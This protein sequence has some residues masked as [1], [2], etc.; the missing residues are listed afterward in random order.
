MPDYG[1]P[2]GFGGSGGGE[3]ATGGMGTGQGSGYGGN[4]SGQ[5]GG[6]SQATRDALAAMAKTDV[7]NTD[8]EVAKSR[9]AK[10][11]DR[12][13]F[14]QRMQKEANPNKPIK[15]TDT[16]SL[17]NTL[18]EHDIDPNEVSI[19]N[20]EQGP[21]AQKNV[22]MH[23]QQRIAQFGA[24]PS[25]GLSGILSKFAGIDTRGLVLSPSLS[26]ELDRGG[27]HNRGR[28][29]T[30]ADPL[31]LQTAGAQQGVT[32]DVATGVPATGIA[33]SLS[34]GA[35]GQ[36]IGNSWLPPVHNPPVYNQG[37]R[38]GM[39]H[40]GMMPSNG[41]AMSESPTVVM[42]VAKSGIGSILDK[43]KQIRAEL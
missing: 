16:L 5:Q 12:Q 19:K 37:G 22:V 36:Q 35:T 7:S 25:F 17:Y 38:V 3:A 29:L 9:L 43:Y 23:N 18:K 28:A 11:R 8:A 1:G 27:E 13:I 39:M 41:M 21:F 4:Q 26:G 24:V 20:F 33:S 32:Q 15:Y 34:T 31:Y 30:P 42:S 40:G 10:E 14:A 2:S 6:M